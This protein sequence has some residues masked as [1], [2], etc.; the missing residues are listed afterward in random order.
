MAIQNQTGNNLTKWDKTGVI[1]ENKPNSQ[2]KIRVD[3]SRRVTIRNRRFIRE[4]NP[5]LRR[6]QVSAPVMGKSLMKTTKKTVADPVPVVTAAPHKEVPPIQAEEPREVVG[7]HDAQPL[8]TVVYKVP[9]DHHVVVV[10]EQAPPVQVDDPEPEVGS[11]RPMR[12][13]KPNSKYSPDV[14]DL[15]YVGS[16]FKTKSRKS[17]RRAGM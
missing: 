14:Y 2:V 5:D 13:A 8:D 7:N 10:E 3:G 6:N 15:S 17:I 12:T 4:L 9:D 11:T 16:K 1:L